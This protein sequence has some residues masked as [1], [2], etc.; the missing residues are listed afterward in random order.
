MTTEDFYTAAY[1]QAVVINR[2]AEGR[3]H[4]LGRDRLDLIH[5]MST[6]AVKELPVGHARQTVL[7]T[8]IARMVDAVWLLN[9]GETALMVTGVGRAAAVRRWLAGYIFFRDEVKLTDAS[10]ELGQVGVYGKQAATVA[11]ALF[12]GAAA[13]AE[14]TFFEREDVLVWR[15]RP[16]A[17]DGFTFIAPAA[18]MESLQTQMAERGAILADD[19]TYNL[20]RLAGQPEAGHELTEDYIP[21]E[22]DL[23]SAVSFNKGCYIGQEI[24]ARMESRGKLARRLAGVTL[25]S[26]VEMGAKI[27][28]AGAEVGTVTSA[29]VL[30]G[31]G[32]VALSVLKT[33]ACEPGVAV[34]VNGVSGVV[35]ALPFVA[36]S[37]H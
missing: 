25:A 10:A 24:I 31:I 21:L 37:N 30:P 35:C 5:R 14:N 29:G 36:D 27:M 1:T 19:A 32:P 13:L 4:L 26:P 8:A 17:G 6:N 28:A 34:D 16:L 9:R 18:Q 15:G 2:S 33:A 3:V 7:T 11:D 12:P 22:T 23:W 20:L